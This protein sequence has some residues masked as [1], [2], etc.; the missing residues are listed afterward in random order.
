MGTTV[1]P[2]LTSTLGGDPKRPLTFFAKLKYGAKL[3][4]S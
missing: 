4:A 1:S 3:A 2:G